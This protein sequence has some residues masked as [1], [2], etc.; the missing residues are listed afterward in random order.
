[1]W[2][3]AV[4]G[5]KGLK[6]QGWWLWSCAGGEGQSYQVWGGGSKVQAALA[7]K[8]QLRRTRGARVSARQRA[9]P[10]EGF[11][12]RPQPAP[13]PALT[14]CSKGKAPSAIS[15]WDTGKGRGNGESCCPACALH[16]KIWPGAGLSLLRVFLSNLTG[17]IGFVFGC[18]WF[19]FVFFPPPPRA[20]A[21]HLP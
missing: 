16:N 10:W 15:C 8:G 2:L 21:V 11:S 4:W 7:P 12:L 14:A 19:C 5:E 6:S 3:P 18:R 1:M 20:S 9:S 13:E 17:Q